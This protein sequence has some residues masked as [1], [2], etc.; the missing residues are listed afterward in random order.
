MFDFRR[1]TLFCSEKRLS[2]H[3]MTI[4]SKDLGGHGPFA[5][6]ATAML[7][8]TGLGP[9]FMKFQ[10]YW[11]NIALMLE[12]F[13]RPRGRTQNSCNKVLKSVYL[14][15]FD[16]IYAECNAMMP[17]SAFYKEP[18]ILLNYCIDEK[19]VIFSTFCP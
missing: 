4:F 5:P 19:D 13:N 11:S 6:L 12:L 9:R 16:E 15:S 3:K 14:T 2:K 18:I 1:I 8:T 10:N 17:K 7:R